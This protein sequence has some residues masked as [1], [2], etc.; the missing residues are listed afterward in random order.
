MNTQD[1]MIGAKIAKAR[2]LRLENE[3]LKAENAALKAEMDSLKAH[4]DLALIAAKDLEK[5]EMEV[6]DGWNLILGAKKEAKDKLELIAQAKVKVRGKGEG[7]GEGVGVGKKVWIVFDGKDENV[8]EEENVRIS[9]TGGEGEQRADRFIADFVRM[10]V[11][12]GLGERVTVRTNDKELNKRV[13]KLRTKAR[14]NP[15]R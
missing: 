5:G 14:S 13:E 15:P 1:L 11:Y 3:K 6:W 2:E 10:A 7:Q 8:V 9:Y 4:F 12:L